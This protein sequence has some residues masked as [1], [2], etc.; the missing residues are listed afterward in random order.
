MKNKLQSLFSSPKQFRLFQ[1]LCLTTLLDFS[2]IA[3]RLYFVGFDLSQIN[4]LQDLAHTRSATFLFLGWNL[5]LAWIP[6]LLSILLEK[7]STPKL[8]A[9]FLPQLL[10]FAWLVFLPNAPYIVTDL[11]HVRY[12]PPVPY[13]YDTLMIFSFAWTGLMLGFLSLLEVQRFLEKHLDKK[14]A[15]VLV[16]VAIGLCAFGIYLGRYQRWNTWDLLMNPYHLFWDTAAVL[17]HPFSYLGTL[18]LAVV[19]AGLLG[20]GYLTLKTLVSDHQ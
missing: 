7:S 5:F 6:Y 2:L 8:Q 4:S 13:W 14:T 19:M 10:L 11:L 15:Q 3:Y 16:W 9:V 20:V 17:F 18:G 1:L 12:R